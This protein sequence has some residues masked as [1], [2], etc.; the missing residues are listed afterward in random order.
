MGN[1][2]NGHV[3]DSPMRPDERGFS[4]IEL[5]IVVGIIG[6]LAAIA[7][8]NLRNA[9]VTAEVKTGA[10]EAKQ[11]LTSFAQY[12][13]DHNQYPNASSDPAFNISTF[14]PLRSMGYY[15]GDINRLL[16]NKQ[17]DDYDS[18][19]DSGDNQEFWLEMTLNVDPRIRILVVDS[20][21][22][23]VSGGEPLNGVF[24]FNNGVMTSF[25]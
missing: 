12:Y 6:L 2:R 18:P 8:P 11:L 9:M 13:R 7:I 5:L 1:P 10:A 19:D 17:A 15:R 25:K 14:E 22:S 20:D 3:A 24:V 4:V 21:D 23:P 16:L